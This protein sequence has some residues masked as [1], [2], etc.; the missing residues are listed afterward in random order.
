MWLHKILKENLVIQDGALLQG[1]P[2]VRIGKWALDWEEGA[3][4]EEPGVLSKES[5]KGTSSERGK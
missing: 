4:L 5:P 1:H 2:W 3:S